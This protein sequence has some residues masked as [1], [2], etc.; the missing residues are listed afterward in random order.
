[1]QR[2]DDR[3]REA[4]VLVTVVGVFRGQG[5]DRFRATPEDRSRQCEP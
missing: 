5:A 1:V 2:V 4:P 3:I